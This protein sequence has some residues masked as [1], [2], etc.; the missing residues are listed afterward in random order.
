[1]IQFFIINFIFIIY[2]VINKYYQIF[3]IFKFD[4]NIYLFFCLKKNQSIKIFIIMILSTNF[5]VTRFKLFNNI[6]K[7]N[8]LFIKT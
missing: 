4:L 6:K 5:D 3:V 7:L 2:Y 1:M 8:V